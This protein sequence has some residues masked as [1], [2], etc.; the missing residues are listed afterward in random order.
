MKRLKRVS[1]PKQIVRVQQ[2]PTGYEAKTFF[3]IFGPYSAVAQ[4]FG[5]MPVCGVLKNHPDKLRFKWFASRTWYTILLIASQF[6]FLSNII[7]A[8]MR[9]G[10]SIHRMSKLM[11]NF[12]V[13]T[14]LLILFQHYLSFIFPFRI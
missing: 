4:V 11:N 14:V 13:R 9:K 12:G 8:I 10:F 1:F 2:I 5:A 7:K 6:W 3:D